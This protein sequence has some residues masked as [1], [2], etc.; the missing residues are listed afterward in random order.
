MLQ[1]IVT[2]F[3]NYYPKLFDAILIH[4]LPFLLQYVFKL[5]QSWLPEDDRK[6]FHLTTKKNLN[7]FV[8]EEQLPNFLG[9]KNPLSYQKVPKNVLSAE[10]LVTKIGL[11][12]KDAGKLKYLEN[13]MNE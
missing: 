6:F 4:E 3:S 13:F 11:K 9:G 5:V 1:F 12:K 7:D 8:A 10:E 2:S